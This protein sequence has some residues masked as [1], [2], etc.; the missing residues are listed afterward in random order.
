MR[1]LSFLFLFVLGTTIAFAQQ[2]DLKTKTFHLDNGL[3]VVMCEDHSQPEIY[4][5]VYVHAG[6]KNDPVDATGMAHYF[7]HIMFKGTDRI[8][9]TNWEAEKVFLDSID[10]MYDRLHE[11]SDVTE[12][13]AI[14]Q[15]IN[16]LSQKSA[17]YAIPNEV[18]VI[19]TQMGGKSLNAGTAYDQT[20]YYNIFP[21]NQ[22]SKWMDVYVERFRNPVFRLF[23]SELET[24]YEE[25]NMY[26]DSPITAFQEYLF[27]ETFGEHPYGRPIIGYTEHLKNPQTSKM[28]EFYNTYYVANN[29][30]LILVGDFDIEATEPLVAEK[31]GT[32]RSGELPKEPDYTLP[33]FDGP[34][35]KEVK[36]T[37]IKMGAIVFPG[38][39]TS[40]PDMLPLTLACMVFANGETGLM[41]KLMKDGDIMAAML[42]PLSLEDH[43][44]NLIFYI[45]KLLGQSHEKAEALVFD[46]LEQLKKGEFSDDLFEAMRMSMLMVRLKETESF[47]SLT[48]LFLGLEMSGQTYEE[49]IDETERLK[50]ITKAEVVAIANKYFGNDYLDVRSKMGFPAKDKVDKPTWKPIEAKNTEAK[51][52]FAKAIET[53]QVPEVEPQ[54][55]RFGEDVEITEVNNSFKLFSTINPRNDIFDL[56]VNFNYGTSNDPDLDRAVQYL[57]MQGTKTQSPEEFALQLQKLGASVDFYASENQFMIH[58][59]G[60]DKDLNDIIALCSRKLQNPSNNEQYIQTLLESEQSTLKANRNDASTWAQAVREY[61][62][63]GDQSTF[64]NHAPLKEWKKRSGEELLAEVAEAFKYDGHATY[65][66]NTHPKLVVAMLNENNLV[67]ANATKGI[68]KIRVEKKF[69]ENQVLIASNKK[70][71]Q[72]NIY[73]HVP[74]EK[75]SDKDEA[76]ASLFS[77]YF[78]T[79]M[80]SIIFQ[81]IREFRSL[82][83]TAYANYRYDNLERKPGHLSGFLGTQSDKTL[84]GMTAF[85]DLIVNMPVRMEKFNASKEALLKSRAS[86]YFGFRDMPSIVQSWMKKGY[87]HDPRGEVTEL[88]RK[89][90]FDDVQ[91]FYTRMIKGRPVVIMMSGN[92]KKIDKKE[93]GKFGSVTKLKYKQ[94]IKE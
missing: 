30:T 67:R 23:Q 20:M 28:R 49:Y 16:V 72:S 31:F 42:A 91:S 10:L 26:G 88:I 69:A 58:M 75:L 25:K 61:A 65:S 18:D 68:E 44:A 8:G 17:D 90:N 34:T 52:D 36:M 50:T 66:G 41:D 4:G 56:R 57:Q 35:V 24:V 7:E 80:Y 13:Q 39:K 47:R 77:K 59:T 33:T 92:E 51:S 70:F 79:D 63:Y 83:Y 5:A 21:S 64:L 29:M 19:L 89:A 1:R 54:V 12:R 81:E 37:P 85:K 53:Q 87:D 6:S 84:D 2:D 43:G 22:L 73:F 93:L 27:R 11:T 82:G 76:M 14:H 46:C 60:F 40:D 94:I 62:L 3:K 71:R 55:I 38:V 48:N 74:G 9:T 86:D 78:G 15:K 45:P 32:W